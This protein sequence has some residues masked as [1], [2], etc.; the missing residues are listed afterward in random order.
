[1]TITAD[2]LQDYLE[3]HE[4]NALFL[5]MV[6]DLLVVKPMD[7]PLC[8]LIS[9]LYEQYPNKW[10]IIE[11]ASSIREFAEVRKYLCN[12]TLRALN[13]IVDS[14]NKHVPDDPAQYILDFVRNKDNFVGWEIEDINA[15]LSD[16][17]INSTFVAVVEDLL[18]ATPPDP[19]PFIVLKF[20]DA[21]KDISLPQSRLIE[22]T[23]VALKNKSFDVSCFDRLQ[24]N[25]LKDKPFKQLEYM[26]KF[27]SD[28]H[29]WMLRTS[30]VLPV[31]SNVKDLAPI[32]LTQPSTTNTAKLP[33]SPPA[34][35]PAAIPVVAVDETPTAEH[36]KSSNS[37]SFKHDDALGPDH[38]SLGSLSVSQVGSLLDSLKLPVTAA[39]LQTNHVDGKV[40]MAIES[41][42]D[43]A[44]L[45]L[46]MPP[47]RA[48]VLMSNIEEFKKSGVPINLLSTRNQAA[49][50][51]SVP[52]EAAIVQPPAL[53]IPLVTAPQTHIF[54]THDWGTDELGRSTH[55]R[56]S[57][58][59]QMLKARGFVTWFDEDRMSGA[60][61]DAMTSGIDHSSCMAVFVTDRYMGKVNGVDGRDNCKIEYNYAFRI[62]G[63]HKMI[64]IVMEPRVRFASAWKGAVGAGLGGLLYID[65]VDDDDS[66]LASRVDDLA[67]RILAVI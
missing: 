59:N 17:S 41:L 23:I 4:L 19:I 31:Q 52:A 24:Q 18:V 32:Q 15:Y 43:I 51:G 34:I 66:V 60:I 56:V 11:N 25:L 13:K 1:M 5:R 33:T 26:D 36:T 30:A 44:D 22:Q 57:K 67:Q 58:I 63:P 8:F 49:T 40:L 38:V 47:I 27:F 14:F 21:V 20:Y 53:K 3:R 64:P 62:L 9:H 10:G 45:G 16:H 12:Y 6:E 37:A 54:L 29:N 48:R 39:Q 7:Y 50:A 55:Q 61:V 28:S 46:V 42:S 2:M 35:V 65:M